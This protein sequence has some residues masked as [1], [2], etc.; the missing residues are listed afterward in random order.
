MAPEKRV[1]G[2]FSTTR[3]IKIEGKILV[4]NQLYCRGNDPAE[5]GGLKDPGRRRA[6]QGQKAR[7][8]KKRTFVETCM[9][10]PVCMVPYRPKE[11]AMRAIYPCVCTR[12]VRPNNP[13]FCRG[14][15][16]NNLK[17]IS[18]FIEEKYTRKRQK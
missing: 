7:G 12:K 9:Y 10:I 14:S 15:H 3:A 17:R 2:M 1:I 4:L 16:E 8:L 5:L 6:K 11:G 13:F 18:R